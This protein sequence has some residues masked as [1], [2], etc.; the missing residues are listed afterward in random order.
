MIGSITEIRQKLFDKLINNGRIV[1]LRT[2]I[3]KRFKKVG[4][5]QVRTALQHV[6]NLFPYT[7]VP[8]LLMPEATRME[9]NANSRE[10]AVALNYYSLKTYYGRFMMD[11]SIPEWEATFS[12][13]VGE[14]NKIL[15]GLTRDVITQTAIERFETAIGKLDVRQKASVEPLMSLILSKHGESM[16]KLLGAR[17]RLFS[18]VPFGKYSSGYDMIEEFT[19]QVCGD[20]SVKMVSLINSMMKKRR[21]DTHLIKMQQEML[22]LRHMVNGNPVKDNALNEL[23]SDLE[24]TFR[25]EILSGEAPKTKDMLVSVEKHIISRYIGSYEYLREFSEQ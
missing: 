10:M 9:L 17:F 8:T 21:S 25:S 22:Y 18:V 14:R 12:R 2:A 1:V 24:A 3:P 20:W 6:K 23:V 7:F 15:A 13:I 4:E 19:A 5:Y 11:A 16:E